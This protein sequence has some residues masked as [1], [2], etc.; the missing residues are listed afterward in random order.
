[1]LNRSTNCL[2][3]RVLLIRTLDHF[4][5]PL[6]AGLVGAFVETKQSFVAAISTV[7]GA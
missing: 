7:M 1:L 6:N 3:Q 2:S 5:G 4:G